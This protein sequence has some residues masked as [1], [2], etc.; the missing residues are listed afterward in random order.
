MK[1]TLSIKTKCGSSSSMSITNSIVSSSSQD[2]RVRTVYVWRRMQ[3]RANYNPII[4][5]EAVPYAHLKAI[6]ESETFDS[7]DESEKQ[8]FE[9][10]MNAACSGYP[11]TYYK[12]IYYQQNDYSKYASGIGEYQGPMKFGRMFAKN[13]MGRPMGRCQGV[14]KI[15]RNTLLNDKYVD[16]DIVNCH[17]TIATHLFQDVEI[18]ALVEY[19]RNR[20]GVISAIKEASR[21]ID[22]TPEIVKRAVNSCLN[23]SGPYFSFGGDDIEIGRAISVIPFFVDLLKERGVM[24]GVMRE[25]YPGLIKV[26]EAICQERKLSTDNAVGKAMSYLLQDVENE[27]LRCMIDTIWSNDVVGKDETVVFLFDGLVVPKTAFAAMEE[28]ELT[29][30]L[31]DEIKNKIGISVSIRVKPMAPVIDG[32][33]LEHPIEAEDADEAAAALQGNMT[34]EAFKEELEK[35][36]YRIENPF[37]YAKTQPDGRVCYYQ[38]SKFV[39]EV[40][41]ESPKDLVK[42]WISDPSKRKYQY[43]DFLPPPMIVPDGV[44]NTWSGFR[45][46]H[47]DPVPDDQVKT[48]TDPLVS[49]VHYLCGAIQEQTSY[50][51]NWL[52]FMVQHPGRLPEV[53]LGFRSVEG[54]GKDSFF[55]FVG[56][57][58]LGDRLFHQ[59]P[60]IGSVFGDRHTTAYKDKILLVVSECSRADSTKNRN[61]LKS[62][63]TATK[64][65]F[66]PLY[67]EESLRSN[68]CGLVMFS[69]DNQFIGLD[70]DDRRFMVMDCLPVNAGNRAYFDRLHEMFADDKYAR[71]FYQLLMSRDLSGW[72]PQASRP[73]SG[74]RMDLVQFAARPF[75]VWFREYIRFTKDRLN[76]SGSVATIF[77]FVETRNNLHAD[78]KMWISEKNLDVQLGEKRKFDSC[79]RVLSQDAITQSENGAFF[80]AVELLNHG[81]IRV[82][83]DRALTF[84]DKYVSSEPVSQALAERFVD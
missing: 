40:L 58:V 27:C 20:D 43:E 17:P 14:K 11:Q 9:R 31:E 76:N 59:A 12:R 70:G 82:H 60:D 56:R 19:V 49:H 69:Q 36:C 5:T 66:R 67:I 68:Y 61:L 33:T 55:S 84:L 83:F 13:N 64:V 25:R 10:W 30:L 52:A 78:Y 29:S 79:L 81:K 15:V 57:K 80:R 26:V 74:A 32:I 21:V 37:C 63:M 2:K 62:F 44:L 35:T 72:H 24:Y 34:Y 46:A 50:V 16:L 8:S 23:G 73:M 38:Q 45:A 6:R 7:L 28:D 65:K 1:Q 4:I 22:V 75:N 3:S 54:T 71:G 53:G 18:P 39:N 42:T 48:L 41:S 51:L 77:S 47:L